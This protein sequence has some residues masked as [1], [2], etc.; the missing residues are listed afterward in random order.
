MKKEYEKTRLEIVL[1]N[2]RNILTTSG[3]APDV[4]QDEN[5]LPFVK[6]SGEW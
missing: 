4:K 1:F 5:E 6:F 3:D 2:G